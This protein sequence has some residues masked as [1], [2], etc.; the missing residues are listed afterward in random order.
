[1]SSKCRG[2]AW[3]ECYTY[4]AY[5]A[6]SAYHDTTYHSPLTTHH[7]LLTRRVLLQLHRGLLAECFKAWH[8]EAARNCGR[9]FAQART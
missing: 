5:S 4:S 7:L 3:E 2:A 9:T 1:M 8:K 6:H